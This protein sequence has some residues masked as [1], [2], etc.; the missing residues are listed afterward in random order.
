LQARG[1][2][3]D[4]GWLHL[5]VWPVHV[6]DWQYECCG[7]PFAIGDRI[8]WTLVLVQDSEGSRGWPKE[9]LVDLRV[10]GR[11]LSEDERNR[12][13]EVVST[14]DG[15]EIAVHPSAGP[16]QNLLRGSLIEEH[17]GGVPDDLRPVEGVVRSLKVVSQ[18]FRRAG[19]TLTPIAGAV[20]L[21]EI[22]RMP[23]SFV[24]TPPDD[25]ALQQ[26]HE[27]G[28]LAELEFD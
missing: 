24:H 21:G 1:R 15:P 25:V 13:V 4:P 8:R 26:W 27:I 16:D 6:E 3:F 7:E 12:Q 23:T 2:R 20:R 14:S 19:R 28:A 17:H 22:E 5:P 9:M 18:Q 11:R 10:V